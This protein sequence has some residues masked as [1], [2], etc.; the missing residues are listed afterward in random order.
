MSQFKIPDEQSKPK[1]KLPVKVLLIANVVGSVVLLLLWQTIMSSPKAAGNELSVGDSAKVKSPVQIGLENPQDF[2]WKMKFDIFETRK[3]EVAKHKDLLRGDYE[4]ST[5]VFGAVEDRKPWWGTAGSAVFGKGL[6]SIL[7]PSEESRFILNPY[8]LVAVNSASLGIWDAKKLTDADVKDPTFPYFWAPS[9]LV[10]EPHNSRAI[11]TYN[12][13]RWIQQ[14][15]SSGKLDKPFMASKFSLVA[16]NAK[17]LNYNFIYFDER[18]S[19]N[20]LNESTTRN[21]VAIRQMIH[22]GGTCGYPGGCNNMS[23]FTAEIDRLAM[24][25]LPA[26]AVIKLWKE[27]PVTTSQKPDF[28]MIIDLL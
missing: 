3:R 13:S 27:Y 19:T 11:A 22:C 23:P 24:R 8:L 17:D 18:E 6:K 7:G 4:P 2:N 20:V 26:R 14:V 12:V 15:S 28:L 1:R 10:F 21:A 9:S 16:Y 25:S 5:K